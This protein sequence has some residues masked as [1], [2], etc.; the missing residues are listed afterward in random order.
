MK[1]LIIIMALAT[2]CHEFVD[3]DDL[4][5]VHVGMH[6]ETVGKILKTEMGVDEV[7]DNVFLVGKN[8]MNASMDKRTSWMYFSRNDSTLKWM[9]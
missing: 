3:R 1:R 2:G 5:K 4:M 7:R 9:W 8:Y 6:V